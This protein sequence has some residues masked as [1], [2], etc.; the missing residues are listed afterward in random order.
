[1]THKLGLP[2]DFANLTLIQMPALIAP[3]IIHF[4]RG[5]SI[6]LSNTSMNNIIPILIL[7]FLP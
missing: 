6:S 4:V 2:I 7:N 3:D 1:M 5:K